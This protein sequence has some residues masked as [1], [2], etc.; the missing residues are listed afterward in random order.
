[1]KTTTMR[2]R[3]ADSD[4]ETVVVDPAPVYGTTPV[5]GYDDAVTGVVG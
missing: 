1:M 3:H 2:P 5:V 4:I